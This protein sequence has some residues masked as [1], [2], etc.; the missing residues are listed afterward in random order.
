MRGRLNGAGALLLALTLGGAVF[1]SAGAA[2][3]EPVTAAADSL[4][5]S[6]YP[7]EPQLSPQL[8]EGGGFGE[9][10]AVPVKGQV[11]AQPLVSGGTL[12]VATEKNWIYA[13]NSRSGEVVW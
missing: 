12:F 5:T 1:C 11:Y 7:D 10:F 4:R 9:N 3:A 13:I 8:V 6:W 2:A